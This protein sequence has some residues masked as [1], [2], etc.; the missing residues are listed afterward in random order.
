MEWIKYDEQKPKIGQLVL[1]YRDIDIQQIY[2]TVWS[3][4]DERYADW[5]IVTHWMPIQY[6]TK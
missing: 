2:A 1:V 4:E 5:N 3:D 6:P